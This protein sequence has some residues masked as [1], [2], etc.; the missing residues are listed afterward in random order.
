MK[1][2]YS[3]LLFSTLYLGCFIACRKD[4]TNKGPSDPD[5]VKPDLTVKVTA[6]VSGFVSDEQDQPVAFASV[7]AGDKT[8]RTDE[9]GYFTFT[10]ASVPKTAGLV[11]V[12]RNGFFAG[13][14][15]FAPQE[16]K[17]NFIRIKLL[18]RTEAGTVDAA[19]GGQATTTDG[20][21]VVLPAGAVVVAT[22]GAAYTG[23]VHVNIRWIDPSNTSGMQTSTPGDSRGTDK[24][25]YLKLLRSYSA[26]A[27]ELTGGSG[28]RLQIAPGKQATI[29]L[30]IPSA[31]SAA[32]PATIDLWRFND[33]TGLWVAEG[34]ATRSGS[35]YTATV[36]H[37]SFWEGAEP[38]SVVNF[39][40]RV[41]NASG[42]PLANVPVSVTQASLPQNA[43]YGKFGYT[44][45]N[46][47][48]S[49]AV[50]A[51]HSLVLDVLT[52]CAVSAYS[53]PFTTNASDIDLGELTGNLGQG[54]VTLTASVVDC[55]NQ[56]VTNGYVQT[57]DHGFYNRIPVSA[58]GTINFTG[59][60][61]TN[62]EISVIAVNNTTHQ[63]GD[64]HTLTLA[65]GVNALGAL[66]ACGTST[67]GSLTYTVNGVP[68]TITEGDL[69]PAGY[70][71]DVAS[72]WTQVLIIGPNSNSN[73]WSFQFDE[74]MGLGDT[75]HVTDIF[76]Q[77]F[78]SGR[79][80]AP[81]PLNVNITEYGKVGGFIT[82]S[83]SGLILDFADN[84][85]YQNTSCSFRIRRNN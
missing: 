21:K 54:L 46:G 51:N 39:S 66:Q 45:A 60:A 55:E 78:K 12:Q 19:A 81:S 49:G 67:V 82:G 16:G 30:P 6:S 52:T 35:A 33:T 36:S 85:I 74:G 79:G 47:Y 15:T 11:T 9:F 65:P 31:L 75:H 20:G 29:S 27:V 64:V 38:L 43:G 24:D 44:D 32:A 70:F 56:P 72:G 23:A 25:G 7:V 42:L 69:T 53:H 14:R 17:Q 61:C 13:Y 34:T 8:A 84:T 22:G 41:V 77:A 83:F 10:N 63:Q 2:S 57:Y 80:Y 71:S 73:Y 58:T 1:N 37:F 48:I 40:A 18:T 50:P 26:V 76:S 59:L 3:L 68:T 62:T 28:E 5:P 4:N